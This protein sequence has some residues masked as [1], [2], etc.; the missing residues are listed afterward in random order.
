MLRAI[1]EGRESAGSYSLI[2]VLVATMWDAVI[3]VVAFIEA[4]RNEESLILF[5]MPAFLL[6]LLFTN[7]ELRIL[8]LIF[9]SMS[10]N[11]S[12]R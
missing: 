1:F 11:A 12:F 6:C 3:C 2:T 8:L 9:Q 4:F 7:L 10:D 5:I